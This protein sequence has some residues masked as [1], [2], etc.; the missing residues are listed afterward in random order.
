M[1]Y[2]RERPNVGQAI[3]FVLTLAGGVTISLLKDKTPAS[4]DPP[5]LRETELA[6]GWHATQALDSD[7]LSIQESS[8][9]GSGIRLSLTRAVP[10][11]ISSEHRTTQLKL[12]GHRD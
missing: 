10:N 12:A 3:G 6:D 2:S 9:L 7:R 8:S 11:N 1:G 4:A 5:T